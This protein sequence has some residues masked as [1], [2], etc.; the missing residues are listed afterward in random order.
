MKTLL[1]L[2]KHAAASALA[3]LDQKTLQGQLQAKAKAMEDVAPADQQ[4]WSEYY[5]GESQRYAGL[6]LQST[7]SALDAAKA[8]AAKPAA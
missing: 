8:E 7:K 4:Q 3:A 5:D 6:A 2:F 1:D